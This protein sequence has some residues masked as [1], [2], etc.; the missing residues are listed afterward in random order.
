[1][2]LRVL[3]NAARSGRKVSSTRP[4]RHSHREEA[5]VG[6]EVGLIGGCADPDASPLVDIAGHHER[7]PGAGGDYMFWGRATPSGRARLRFGG[8]LRRRRR[9]GARSVV[10][11][12]CRFQDPGL[13]DGFLV[14]SSGEGNTLA[15]DHGR[16]R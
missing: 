6:A 1:M 7:R 11:G 13:R 4:R 2:D 15:A 12:A 16:E 8:R 10:R 3:R 9:I 14:L 5:D